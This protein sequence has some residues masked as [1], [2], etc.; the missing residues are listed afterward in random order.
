MATFTKEFLSG[1]AGDG[2][3]IIINPTA[4]AGTTVHT[5][6]STPIKDEIF[7]YAFNTDTDDVIVTLEWGGVVDP[8]NTIEVVVPATDGLHLLTPGLILSNDDVVKCFAS[9]TNVIV[10]YGFVNRIT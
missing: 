4:T 1:G 8:D 6:E 2:N 5:A 3:G 9:V 10:I 7:I